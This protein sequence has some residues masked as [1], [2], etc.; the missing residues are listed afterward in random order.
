MSINETDFLETL[1]KGLSPMEAL[2]YNLVVLIYIAIPHV[3]GFVAMLAVITALGRTGIGTGGLLILMLTTYAVTAWG[4][5]SSL[6]S[7]LERCVKSNA[8]KRAVN[9][10]MNK[11]DD[12]KRLFLGDAFSSQG[13]R[14]E[15]LERLNERLEDAHFAMAKERLRGFLG[16]SALKSPEEID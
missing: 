9:N 4:I 12:E 1:K 3:I 2:V 14:I 16:K 8:Y 5:W 7:R 11:S 15:E 6:T 13:W 10:I